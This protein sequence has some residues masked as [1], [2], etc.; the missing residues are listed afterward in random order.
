MLQIHINRRKANSIEFEKPEI[1]VPMRPG[2]E[3]SFEIALINYGTPTRVHLSTTDSIRNY[4]TFLQDNPYVTNQE[5]IPV[6]VKLPSDIS[7]G[8]GKIKVITGYGSHTE[9]I[10]V[11]IGGQKVESKP[12][13]SVD[14]DTRLGDPK[15]KVENTKTRNRK[16]DVS[17]GEKKIP[18]P[19]KHEKLI[20][21]FLMILLVTWIL[22]IT[23]VI[24]IFDP[25]LGALSV[26][27]I[28][29]FLIFYSA[30]SVM[31]S[32]ITKKEE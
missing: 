27:I 1:K 13:P 23:F 26:S 19:V 29:I 28:L 5:W 16:L 10:N 4:V 21:P 2:G 11:H 15:Y 12:K 3:C 31:S 32:N 7:I 22:L 8:E 18:K 17:A 25:M 6:V 20:I 30:I 24:K 9:T 14:V